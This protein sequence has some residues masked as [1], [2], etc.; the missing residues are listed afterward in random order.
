MPFAIPLTNLIEVLAHFYNVID[1]IVG[2][3]EEIPLVKHNQ[4]K[5]HQIIHKSSGNAIVKITRYLWL[6]MLMTIV[7]LRTSRKSHTVIFFMELWAV[8][9]AGSGA[10]AG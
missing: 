10:D 9:S 7:L 8:P 3:Y 2:S 1:V 6:Q 4:V 5:Y